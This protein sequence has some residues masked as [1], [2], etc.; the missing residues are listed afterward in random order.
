MSLP[1]SCERIGIGQNG[2]GGADRAGGNRSI[3]DA[4]TPRAWWEVI[5]ESGNGG[6]P[7]GSYRNAQAGKA[8][9]VKRRDEPNV[10]RRGKRKREM[11]AQT[12]PQSV[13]GARE[14]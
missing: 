5:Y 8:Q 1:E 9:N 4:G 13:L 11:I 14:E 6:E 7:V 10:C 12:R 2:G 3:I